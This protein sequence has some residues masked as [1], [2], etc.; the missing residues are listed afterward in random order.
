M[1]VVDKYILI[2]TIN[3]ILV[4]SQNILANST[5][6][7]NVSF[8]KTIHTFTNPNGLCS[9]KWCDNSNNN[10]NSLVIATLGRSVGEVMI[11]TL[12]KRSNIYIQA[13]AYDITNIAIDDKCELIST[14]SSSGTLVNIFD[15]STCSKL[16]QFRRGIFGTIIHDI[17]FDN[18]SNYVICCSDN[19]TIHVFHLYDKCSED[20]QHKNTT[21]N[22]SLLGPIMPVCHSEWA[23]KLFKIN[24]G[25]KSNC[26]F[27]K[28]ND[29]INIHVTSDDLM[30]YV[31][32]DIETNAD[33]VLKYN[34]TSLIQNK[35]NK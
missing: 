15:I 23:Y 33:K 5:D 4:Y 34:L 17:E 24:A 30:Y 11:C 22:F 7:N 21:S 8:V 3:Q 13:H 20:T 14:T 27:V 31:I 18:N 12:K 2:V 32:N 35:Q 6:P 16:Y 28:V 9:A 10:N 1:I 25:V 29:K 26:Y 19:G